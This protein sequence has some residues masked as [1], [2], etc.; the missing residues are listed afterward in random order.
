[1]LQID[2]TVVLVLFLRFPD[3]SADIFHIDTLLSDVEVGLCCS[4][5]N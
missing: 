5:L 2:I 4:N 3:Y 1:M